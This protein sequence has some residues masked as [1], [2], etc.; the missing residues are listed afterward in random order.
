MSTPSGIPHLR[1]FLAP[2]LRL[3]LVGWPV[4]MMWGLCGPAALWC[5]AA[6]PGALWAAGAYDDPSRCSREEN[7]VMECSTE[8]DV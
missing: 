4:G 8:A 2:R 3:W 5:R 6:A 7:Q 1:V